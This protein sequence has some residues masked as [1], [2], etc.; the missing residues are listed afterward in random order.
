MASDG[1]HET[2]V[3]DDSNRLVATKALPSRRLGVL[4]LSRRPTDYGVPAS[5]LVCLADRLEELPLARHAAEAHRAEGRERQVRARGELADG[6]G[7]DDLARACLRERPRG[8][9]DAD[10]ADVVAADLDLA[11]MDRD[12]DVQAVAREPA[13]ERER[14]AQRAGRRVE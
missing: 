1:I 2:A 8:D 9:V 6:S 3:T 12:P 5:P 13:P 14:A 7:H 4:R 10:P 11:A